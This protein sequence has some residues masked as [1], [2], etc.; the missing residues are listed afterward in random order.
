MVDFLLNFQR[1]LIAFCSTIFVVHTPAHLDL[2]NTIHITAIMVVDAQSI[3]VRAPSSSSQSLFA[4]LIDTMAERGVNNDDEVL[5]SA[6]LLVDPLSSLPL[7]SYDFHEDDILDFVPGTPLADSVARFEG[8]AVTQHMKY[9]QR[10]NELYV[11]DS[12]QECNQNSQTAQ[13]QNYVQPESLTL[14][15]SNRG[16]DV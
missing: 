12:D 10:G 4:A 11:S 5:P 15:I 1:I 2:K 14:G 7:P 16:E 8:A 9:I 6:S 3:F 13:E